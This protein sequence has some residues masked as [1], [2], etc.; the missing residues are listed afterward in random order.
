MG[1]E[2]AQRHGEGREG[3]GFESVSE[4]VPARR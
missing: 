3:G 1:S 2:A 4:A